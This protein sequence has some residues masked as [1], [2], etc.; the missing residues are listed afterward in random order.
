MKLILTILVLVS[1]QAYS[2]SISLGIKG[3]ITNTQSSQ[4]AGGFNGALLF[5]NKG[6]YLGIGGTKYL[7]QEEELWR[8]YELFELFWKVK[9]ITLGSFYGY[10][11]P[12]TE[13]QLEN[14]NINDAHKQY[15]F[16]IGYGT[17]ISK[18]IEMELEARYHIWEET[19]QGDSYVS[20]W[21]NLNYWWF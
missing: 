21:I 15:G 17:F 20:T 5:G 8:D 18:S 1:A 9:R 2:F 6:N 19:R 3:G 10:Y 4:F 7:Y 12:D 13:S 14:L 11:S 16:K